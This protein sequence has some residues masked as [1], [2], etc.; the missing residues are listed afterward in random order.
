MPYADILTIIFMVLT[1]VLIVGIL[2]GV[3]R[4]L[5]KKE[6]FIGQGPETNVGGPDTYDSADC[7]YD[8][9]KVFRWDAKEQDDCAAACGLK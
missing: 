5:T 6:E 8:C 7:F 4:F 2:F 9:M 3:A 1:A